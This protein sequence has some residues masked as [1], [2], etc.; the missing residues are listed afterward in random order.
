MT[1]GS[2]GQNRLRKIQVAIKKT[3]EVQGPRVWTV[4]ELGAFYTEHRSAL[5]AH[6]NRVLKDSAKTMAM[7]QGAEEGNN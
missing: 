2:V 3:A 6:A 5:L 1:I 4:A 7:L